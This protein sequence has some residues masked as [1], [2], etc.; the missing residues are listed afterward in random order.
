MPGSLLL[1]ELLL[2]QG[3]QPGPWLQKQT[4]I[5]F[6]AT[7]SLS[8]LVLSFDT[9]PV[10]YVIFVFVVKGETEGLQLLSNNTLVSLSK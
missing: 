5:C 3:L 9:S 8:L 10:I 1:V 2:G 4:L 6:P 7:R